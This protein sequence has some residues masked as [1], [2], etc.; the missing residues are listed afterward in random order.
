MISPYKVLVYT[1]RLPFSYLITNPT[2]VSNKIYEICT[3]FIKYDRINILCESV[4]KLSVQ[5]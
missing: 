2:T 1:D 3:E 4:L 5:D